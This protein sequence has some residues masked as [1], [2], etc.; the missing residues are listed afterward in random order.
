VNLLG[1]DIGGTNTKVV[2]LSPENSVIER[3]EIPTRATEGPDALARRLDELVAGW[4]RSG[5]AGLSVAGLMSSE[6][7]VVQAPNLEAFVRVDLAG[8]FE[9]FGVLALEND[10]NCAIYGEWQA[11]AGQGTENLAMLSLGTGVGGGLILGGELYHGSGGIGAELGH[12]TLD[13]DGPECPC[14]LRGHVESWLG[15]RGFVEAGRE[16]AVAHP[17]SPLAEAVDGG[18]VPDARLLTGLAKAGC[19][20]A[21]EAI[22]D[23]GRWLGIACA[24]VVAVLQPDLILV[25]GGSARCGD[26]LL[27]PA[28]EEYDR[29]C[30]EAAR[31]TVEVRLAGLGVE[32]AA[33][34][35][36][37]LA[38]AN[39]DADHARTR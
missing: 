10:V 2:L 4:P 1:I 29:R 7:V 19:E 15:S 5:G 13:P 30:M 28:L 14:G 36:A 31:G 11:G 12:M 9:R 16:Y 20:A 24:N 17:R 21:R 8:A 34:G 32:S 18:E 37:L 23:R 22:A 39:L 33:I 27:G 38:R 35:A 25:A 26:L 6:R 3:G